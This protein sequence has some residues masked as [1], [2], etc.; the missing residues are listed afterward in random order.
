MSTSNITDLRA[1]LFAQLAELRAATS[2][3]GVKAAVEK[4]RAV[5]EL[6]QV[7]I[8][9]ARVELDHLKIIGSRDEVPF[10]LEIEDDN[11]VPNGITGI[12][13]HRIKG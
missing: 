9:S 6:G 12:V 8:N 2:A 5:S 10:F 4:S 1:A 13:R 3:E 7:L 11:V